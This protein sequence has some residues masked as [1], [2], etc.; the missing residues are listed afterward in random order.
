MTATRVGVIVN[1]NARKHLRKPEL[2]DAYRA[3]GAVVYETGSLDELPD[4]CRDLGDAG[5]ETV[6]LS[7]GDG[8]VHRGLSALIAAWEGTPP[9]IAILPAGTMNTVARGLGVRGG[10]LAALHRAVSE[11]PLLRTRRPIDAGNG[12]LGFLVGT[13]FWARF[14]QAYDARTGP[15]GVRAAAVLTRGLASTAVRGTF[16]R[17]MFAPIEAVVDWNGER[18]EQEQFTM[19]AAGVVPSVGLGFSPFRGVLDVPESLHALAFSSSPM[20][21]ARQLPALFRGHEPAVPDRGGVVQSLRVQSSMALDWA[22]D[23]DVQEPTRDL[24]LRC[25]PSL[26]FVIG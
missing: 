14:L 24:S 10:P 19:I 16:V 11:T 23:G 6:A 26:S 1:R 12:K 17:D 7:G 18:M 13:G 9:T 15:G 5:V 2:A 3:A 4:V 8:A 22:I 21:V 25:G 20:R